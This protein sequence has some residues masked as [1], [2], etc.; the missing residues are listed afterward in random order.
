MNKIQH[1][2][3]SRNI[4]RF[5]AQG[6]VF[7]FQHESPAILPQ[8]RLQSND[9]QPDVNSKQRSGISIWPCEF[10]TRIDAL[11]LVQMNACSPLSGKRTFGVNLEV[12][13]FVGNIAGSL[14]ARSSGRHLGSITCNNT[15]ELTFPCLHFQ[16]N[17]HV[18][19]QNHG[20]SV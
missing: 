17:W 3:Y 7:R 9:A 20:H 14:D 16:T 8:T 15:R 6:C 19:L 2:V 1:K 18:T 10:F 5:V 4:W 13:L 11:S 12:R